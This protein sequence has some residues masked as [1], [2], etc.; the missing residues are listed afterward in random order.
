MNELNALAGLGLELPSPAYLLGCLIFSVIGYI[1]FRRGR[2]LDR[3]ALTWGGLALMLYPYGVSS[4]TQ[5]WALGI[6]LCGWLYVR[7]N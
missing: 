3:S 1:A 5:L 2:K 7:W 4:T 6:A